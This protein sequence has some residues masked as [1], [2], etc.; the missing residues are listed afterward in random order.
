MTATLIV[1]SGDNK[2]KEHRLLQEK[3]TI[4]RAVGNDIVIFDPEASR[5]HLSLTRSGDTFTLTD[6]QSTNGTMVNGQSVQS[7]DLKD[8]DIIQIGSLLLVFQ[9]RS[10][11]DQLPAA[12]IR[13]AEGTVVNKLVVRNESQSEDFVIKQ[14]TVSIGRGLDNDL[15]LQDAGASRQH[16][17]I[18]RRGGQ[19]VLV[20]NGSLNGTLVGGTEVDEH[21]LR[22]GD[23]IRIGQTSLLFRQEVQFHIGLETAEGEVAGP[24][25]VLQLDQDVITI[26]RDAAN[27]IVLDNPRVSRRHC[28]IRREDGQFVII[29]LKSTN[30]TY[31]NGVRVTKEK[32]KEGDEVRVADDKFLFSG[33]AVYQSSEEGKIKIDALHLCKVVGHNNTIL[34]DISLSIR[35]REFVALVGGSGCG[36]STLLDALNGSRPATSGTL[37]YNGSDYY[38]NSDAYRS[39]IGYVP[40]EDIIH[41]EL[42]VSEALNYA[43]RL[44]LPPDTSDKEIAER[45]ED[46][47]DDLD[48]TE[49]RDTVVQSLSGGQRKRVSIGVELLTKPSLFFLDEPTSGLDPGL[50]TKMMTLLRK[51]ADQGRTVILV[52]HATQNVELCDKL[53]FLAPHGYLA[54]F[55]PPKEALKHFGVDRYS[56][57][58]VEVDEGK[59]P[60]E[61]AKLFASSATYQRHVASRLPVV[62]G[63]EAKAA[64]RPCR[65]KAGP[66]AK[67]VSSLHQ[68]NLLTRRYLEITLRDRRNLAVL[69]LQAPIIAL[70]ILAVFGRHIFDVQA[71]NRGYASTVTFLLAI[72]ATW[73]GTSNAAR[74][75][76][77]ELAIYRRERMINLR[78]APY[79]FSK[80]AVLC[81]ISLVQGLLLVGIVGIGMGFAFDLAV[82]AH[83]YAVVV[84]TS[85][86][87]ITLGLLISAVA[88]NSD[89]ASNFVPIVLIPQIIFS[90]AIIP[91]E[92]MGLLAK[93]ISY[94]MVSRWSYSL[95]GKTLGVDRVPQPRI[96]I[97]TSGSLDIA[98][99]EIPLLTKKVPGLIFENN[100]W[101]FQPH[102]PPQF[103]FDILSHWVVLAAF[104]TILVVATVYFLARRDVR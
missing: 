7:V 24:P 34:H 4:G 103:Q 74:E 91:L 87:A 1:A 63:S 102:I 82:M 18:E 22:D 25:K 44:R 59:E 83:T 21:V 85:L 43:A 9:D 23:E 10:D 48:L 13:T 42:T 84:G 16:A 80:L 52:T 86:V 26:G 92:K 67:K 81:G 38:A 88:S 99:E 20:D 41:R 35:P 19:F 8:G 40:Q 27:D 50:E 66:A 61:W 72:V 100:H 29:D 39:S 15:V 60:E 56:E 32:L 3:T 53:I 30:G 75:V 17:R 28:E 94:L 70:L 98:P 33:D 64:T 97:E 79:V 71:G 47:I 37:L 62:D 77:K 54:F 68:F 51:L 96:P 11:T 69:L 73:F 89:R 6:L 36:K 104:A 78:L 46:V 49:C 90:G 12:G 5:Y 95:L 55:G 65:V 31:V 93:A 14:E 57:V 76:V 2:G 101:Y 58:Y 45:V